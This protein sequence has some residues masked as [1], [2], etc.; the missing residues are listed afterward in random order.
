MKKIF[1]ISSVFIFIFVAFLSMKEPNIQRDATLIVPSPSAQNLEEV[2]GEDECK[3]CMS[4]ASETCV[5]L[6]V[7]CFNIEDCP[8]HFTCEESNNYDVNHGGCYPYC[9]T[10]LVDTGN[11]SDDLKNCA[12]SMCEFEC[13][14]TCN[15]EG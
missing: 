6:Y 13:E 7:E 5:E 12:C 1:I 11:L 3:N 14:A 9:Q 10:S 4:L 8:E 2:E 15:L